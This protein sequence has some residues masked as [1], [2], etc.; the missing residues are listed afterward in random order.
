MKIANTDREY[1]L[2]DLRIFTEIFR[3]DVTYDNIKSQ[4][5]FIWKVL[6]RDINCFL[7]NLSYYISFR[8][9]EFGYG[10]HGAQCRFGP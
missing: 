3:K 7:Q 10:D 5:F 4:I 6:E 1:L 8:T 9:F 2:I